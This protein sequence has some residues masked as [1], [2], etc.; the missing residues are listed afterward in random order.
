MMQ[1]T[2]YQAQ[3]VASHQSNVEIYSMI[4]RLTT[5]NGNFLSDYVVHGVLYAH[6]THC[7]N[8]DGAKCT[9]QR[10]SIRH[11]W[12]VVILGFV[13]GRR[14]IHHQGSNNR[15]YCRGHHEGQGLSM[16]FHSGGRR[17]TWSSSQVCRLMN[18]RVEYAVLKQHAEHLVRIKSVIP[19][20]VVQVLRAGCR[21]VT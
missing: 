19:L 17:N 14:G 6:Y 3:S 10:R 5:N 20:G 1:T 2:G 15:D 21:S 4:L 8:T 16:R 9:Q 18:R 7:C 13:S 12:L 11:K